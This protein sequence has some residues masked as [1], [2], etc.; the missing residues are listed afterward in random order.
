MPHFFA[1]QTARACPLGSVVLTTVL[2][3]GC[4]V[5][6]PQQNAA[7]SLA[8]RLRLAEAME[9][10]APGSQATLEL[11]RAE[12]VRSP[13]NPDVWERFAIRLEE[14]GR[15]TE[16]AEAMRRAIALRGPSAAGL[17]AVGR[18]E[19]RL[20][21]GSAAADA[22]EQALRYAPASA[23]AFG[24]LGL[25]RDL[26]SR[27]EDAQAA[28]QRALALAPGNW[29]YRSNLAL[30]YLMTDQPLRAAETLAEAEW[31]PTAPRTAR[32]NLALALAALGQR[33]RVVALLSTEMG[34]DDARRLADSMTAFAA[35]LSE[36][37]PA[38]SLPR[39]EAVP[40]GLPQTSAPSTPSPPPV[41]PRAVPTPPARPASPSQPAQRPAPAST[42]IAPSTE[43]GNA[44][45]TR[46]ALP[47][48]SSPPSSAPASAP[49]S[50]GPQSPPAAIAAPTPVA[51][52]PRANVRR[53]LPAALGD[54]VPGPVIGMP[55][56]PDQQARP[57]SPPRPARSPSA[58]AEHSET[59][60]MPLA[61]NAAQRGAG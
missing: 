12:T 8:A 19:L 7:L 15:F 35:W 58:A 1:R 59:D 23:E 26:E 28:Y 33:T 49:V 4:A 18:L 2:L 20:G 32:H 24:G 54:P 47:P 6:Q 37:N 34:P 29:A 13:N 11:L 9:Q 41:T 14:A 17:I 51:P 40:A 57:P 50:P 30:S 36:T 16:A 42:S 60:R 44:Q 48:S 52:Q 45:P 46:P 56:I 25:A 53:D 3:A 39:A 21:N 5:Q 31:Q 38:R 55:P 10:A 61:A 43:Q 27:H 22:F